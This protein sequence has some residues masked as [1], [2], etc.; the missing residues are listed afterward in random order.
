M[1]FSFIFIYYVPFIVDTIVDRVRC[2]QIYCTFVPLGG[3]HI[4]ETVN[5]Q[6]HFVQSYLPVEHH[7][8]RS[9]W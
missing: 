3:D 9:F 7:R 5:K 4:S 8:F 1:R 6:L 2:P